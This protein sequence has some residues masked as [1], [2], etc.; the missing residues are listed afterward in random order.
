MWVHV[1]AGGGIVLLC[2]CGIAV[3]GDARLGMW[4]SCEYLGWFGQ[5]LYIIACC[6]FYRT[7]SLLT[8]QD[9]WYSVNTIIQHFTSPKS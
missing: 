9:G 4:Y 2:Q 8:V 5:P 3:E 6:F 1:A 7:P